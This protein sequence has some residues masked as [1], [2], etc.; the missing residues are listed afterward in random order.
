[1][2]PKILGIGAS[3]RNARRGETVWEMIGDLLACGTEDELRRYLSSEGETHLQNVMDAGRKD[4]LPFDRIYK[5]LRNRKTRRG[6]SNSETALAAAL[7]A[8]NNAGCDIDCVTLADHFTP[9][10]GRRHLSRLKDHLMEA[11]GLIISTPVYFGD[12]S[13]LAQQLIDLIRDDNELLS[14]LTEKV[15]CG[16]AVGAKRNGGQETTLI[17]QLLDAVSTGMLG[18]GNDS[19]TTAQYGGTGHAGD[20]GSMA[21][22][23]YG[24]WTSM[25]AGRRSAHVAGLMKIGQ[26][27]KIKGK[28]RVLFWLLQDQNNHAN[29]LIDNLVEKYDE[30]IEATVIK[31]TEKM[32]SSCI[33]CDIC[34]TQVDVDSKYR[35]IIS[36]TRTDHMEQI[37]Q[38]MLSHDAFIP[39]VYCPHD[40]HNLISNYQR[41]MERTRYLRRGDYLLGDCMTAPLVIEDLG[42]KHNMAVRMITSSIRHHTVISE[43][44]VVYRHEDQMLNL[45]SVMDLFDKFI[46]RTR[47]LTA[48]RL[49]MFTNGDRPG[50]SKYNPVG[51]ILSSE[52]DKDDEK[53]RLR[54]KKVRQREDYLASDAAA[55]LDQE[56]VQIG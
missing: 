47:N 36:N 5:N 41:F 39:V 26:D 4:G 6:L 21:R 12:R 3:L 9:G 2:R 45:N 7:W 17:Y 40:R 25:G 32:I 24:L 28:I 20:V 43:P 11:D 42:V 46:N 13:S 49:K 51:Y 15:Y 33:A 1:M 37:H 27:E 54:A 35:C 44:M 48:G 10:G 16:I 34:P 8:A 19:D 38:H 53:L 31:V 23:D 14:A 29:N 55:R 50:I 30:M 18:V 22:D 56:K 52:K